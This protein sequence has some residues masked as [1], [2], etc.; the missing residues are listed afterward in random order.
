MRVSIGSRVSLDVQ[1]AR[2][3]DSLFLLMT[4]HTD[5]GE[6]PIH[7]GAHVD[8]LKGIAAWFRNNYANVVYDFVV[9]R[10]PVQR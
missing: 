9:A 2:D 8:T 7:V 5:W 6:I 3:G 4:V 10:K 1:T